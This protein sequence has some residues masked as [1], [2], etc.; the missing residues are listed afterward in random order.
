M[1]ASGG[2]KG[3][4]SRNQECWDLKTIWGPQVYSYQ[5]CKPQNSKYKSHQI[6]SLDFCC[7]Y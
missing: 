7:A 3:R 1:E 5:V 6:A 2:E 4:K